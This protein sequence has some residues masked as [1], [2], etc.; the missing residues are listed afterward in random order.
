MVNS[1]EQLPYPFNRDLSAVLTHLDRRTPAGRDRTANDPATAA[2]LAAGIRLIR[3]HLGPG[4]ERKLTNPDDPETLS[5]PVLAFLSQRTVAN[6]V[7]NNPDP[8]HKVGT[9][10]MLRDRWYSQSDYIA[11]LLAFAL[12]SENEAVE[13]QEQ[14]AVEAGRIIEGP[15]FV[16]AAHRLAYE[17]VTRVLRSPQFRLE[18]LTCAAGDGDDILSTALATNQVEVVK[19]WIQLYTALFAARGLRLRTGIS[20]EQFGEMLASLVAGY[21]QRGLSDSAGI[22]LDH[23]AKRS[24]FGTAVLALFLGCVHRPEATNSDQSVEDL[25]QALVYGNPR[26]E[27]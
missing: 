10:G 5:R 25:A 13:S 14:I 19:P 12:W 9:V 22:G 2:Y 1:K 23:E 3:K 6:E 4:A 17:E 7:A 27:S 15:D 16:D 18:L 26:Q 24:T 20:V 11:D 8:F 21:G